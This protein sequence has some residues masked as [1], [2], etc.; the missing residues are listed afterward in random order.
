VIG[1]SDPEARAARPLTRREERRFELV[2]AIILAIATLTTA[3]S[4]CQSD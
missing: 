4:G 2:A 3:W 1:G